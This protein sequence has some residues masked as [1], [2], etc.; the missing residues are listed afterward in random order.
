MVKVEFL[1]PIARETIELEVNSLAGLSKVLY[2]DE[3][4]R[5]L[6]KNLFILTIERAF[7]LHR[8]ICKLANLFCYTQ[9][10]QEG[11]ANLINST[12]FLI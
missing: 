6:Q 7:W 1:G 2:E 8:L 10:I 11:C 3:N 9:I 12:T 4:I 5:V